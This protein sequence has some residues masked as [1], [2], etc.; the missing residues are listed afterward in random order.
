MIAVRVDVQPTHYRKQLAE[1]KT[2]LRL[3]ASE[4]ESVTAS[5]ELSYKLLEDRLQEQWRMLAV[6]PD[7]FDATAAAAV[8]EV[9]VDAGK[10]SLSRLV[11]C[12]MLEWNEST[13]RYRTHDLMHDFARQR[14]T[15]AESYVASRRH[16]NR[17]GAVLATADAT[18][19]KGGQSIA[20]GLAL[21]DLEW[22]NI[23]TGQTWT[24][25]NSEHD[26]EAATLCSGYSNWGSAILGLRQHPPDRPSWLEAALAASRQLGDR[27]AEGVHLG[28]LGIA[29]KNIGN[30]RRA[31][32]C[33]EQRLI[34]AR[35]IGD[36]KGEN[37]ALV[38]LGGAYSAAGDNQ[39]AIE[40][41]EKGLEMSRELG[42][43]RGEE[44][45]LGNLGAAHCGLGDFRRSVEYQEQHLAIAQEIGDKRGEGNALG[46][47]GMAH[48]GLGNPRRA[49]EYQE[50][51]LNIARQIGHRLGESNAL[52]NLGVAYANLGETRRAINYYEQKLDISRDIGDRYGEGIALS[53]ISVALYK[54]GDSKSALEHAECAL[55]V[56]EQI[57]HPTA[58][59]VKERVADW[60][61]I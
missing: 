55:K 42:D 33:H 29:L 39:R 60:R 6:F 59:V 8:W 61:K 36:R 3:L 13:K 26:R 34:I 24:A 46:G 18:Y 54:L 30:Y 17:Y 56:L 19:R 31:I 20:R 23:Q 44:Y 11:Q 40:Y 2:R 28:N 15:S 51:H 35:E 41:L 27:S 52:G 37:A 47:L 1:E 21:F 16:A 4:E 43:R 57:K 7:T 32:E 50:Q 5:I 49:I 48:W 12:S 25:L 45:T 58:E 22:R 14:L 10:E 38:N 9:E 53:N